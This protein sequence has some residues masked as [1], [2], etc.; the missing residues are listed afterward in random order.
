MAENYTVKKE[1]TNN[2]FYK[3]SISSNTV[4]LLEF[5]NR[6]FQLLLEFPKKKIVISVAAPQ[7]IK[8]RVFWYNLFSSK[9]LCRKTRAID[10]RAV[11]GIEPKP[12]R[13]SAV[14]LMQLDHELIKNLSESS[15][16]QITILKIS[17]FYSQ[18]DN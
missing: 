4:R 15:G 18:L 10:N 1:N 7:L 9:S 2:K 3:R 17:Y 5:P 13:T 11:V 6:L 8:V 16:M 14:Q 12:S